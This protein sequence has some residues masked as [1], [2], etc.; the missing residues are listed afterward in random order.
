MLKHMKHGNQVQR[1]CC[2]T[3]QTL[4]QGDVVDLNTQHVPGVAGITRVGFNALG[5]KAQGVHQINELATAGANVQTASGMGVLGGVQSQAVLAQPLST[6][7]GIAAR[8]Q[9]MA[10]GG[11]HCRFV[12]LPILRCIPFGQFL[13][14]GQRVNMAQT[15]IAAGN[16]DQPL[17]RFAVLIGND[18][19][20]L[21]AA[22]GTGRM[23][24]QWC[25][26]VG[27]GWGTVLHCGIVS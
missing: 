11:L 16:G 7:L 5:L 27:F 14:S 18:L 6:P 17:T 15:A 10:Q 13:I 21:A 26:C 19:S 20:R 2:L 4:L 25:A 22:T 9:D 8:P 24:N 1:T 12:G 23:G 3:G